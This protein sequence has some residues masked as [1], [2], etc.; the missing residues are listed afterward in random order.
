MWSSE[1]FAGR[2]KDAGAQVVLDVRKGMTRPGCRA[3]ATSDVG[4]VLGV[5]KTEP[6]GGWK[7]EI[8]SLLAPAKK[9]WL[10]PER[11]LVFT[12]GDHQKPGFL[13]WCRNSSIH[14]REEM[15]HGK[16]DVSAGP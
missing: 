5:A 13:R 9:P 15:V 8:H 6:Y 2:L 14:S 7:S 4:G 16:T 1:Q 3:I 12:L 11:W 10:K